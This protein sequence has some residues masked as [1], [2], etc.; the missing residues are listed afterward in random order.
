PSVAVAVLRLLFLD[1]VRLQDRAPALPG[2]DELCLIGEPRARRAA[3]DDRLQFFRAEHRAA[4]V[5][6]EMIVV[7]RQHRRAVE[8]FAG[9]PDAEDAR[10][11]DAHFLAERVLRRA[12]AESPDSGGVAQLS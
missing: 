1:I 10:V 6:R 12:R 5:R 4:A 2:V 11:L 8:I 3:D 9:R 7:V